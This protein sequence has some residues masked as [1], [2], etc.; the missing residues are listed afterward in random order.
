MGTILDL[1]KQGS[2]TYVDNPHWS[3]F[4]IRVKFLLHSIYVNSNFNKIMEQE[5]KRYRYQDE[6]KID[7]TISK[8]VQTEDE[9]LKQQKDRMNEKG[10][11]LA[12]TDQGNVILFNI[13]TLNDRYKNEN[14]RELKNMKYL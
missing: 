2:H 11:Y 5:A 12:N 6:I 7:D 10:V 1:S 14:D 3:V 13:L 9:K 8:E 4:Q